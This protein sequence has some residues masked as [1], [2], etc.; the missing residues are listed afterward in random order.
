MQAERVWIEESTD[1]VFCLVEVLPTDDEPTDTVA[2][3]V[4][5]VREWRGLLEGLLPGSTIT[6]RHKGWLQRRSV[7]GAGWE[8]RFF[9]PCWLQT[10]STPCMTPCAGTAASARLV[11]PKARAA[12]PHPGAPAE[13]RGSS[14]VAYGARLR[15][16]QG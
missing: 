4:G 15:P 5:N 7:D 12:P 6:E 9:V 2:T 3:T 11:P 8:L 14:R 16:P 1:D 10:P 13:R